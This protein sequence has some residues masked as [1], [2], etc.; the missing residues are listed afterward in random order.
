MKKILHVSLL[1]L[2][3]IIFLSCSEDDN[4]GGLRLQV[5][6]QAPVLRAVVKD[7]RGQI[8]IQENLSENLYSF[9]SSPVFPLVAMSNAKDTFIDVDFDGNR[10]ASDIVF[11]DTLYSISNVLS[12]ATTAL[13]E[14]ADINSTTLDY[15]V[16]KYKDALSQY[17]H[18]F[19]ISSDDILHKTPLQSKKINL[20]VL[21]DT[22]YDAR[23]SV[24]FNA[25]DIDGLDEKFNTVYNFYNEY[26]NTKEVAEAARYYAFYNALNLLDKKKII[27][28]QQNTMPS[29]PAR[30]NSDYK[31]NIENL[32]SSAMLSSEYNG[33]SNLAYWAMKVDDINDIAYIASGN[34][35]MD[36]VDITSATQRLQ[37]LD[38]N[39]SGFGTSVEYMD[40][41]N[42]RC[43]FLADQENQ[44][45]IYGIWG[46]DS[47]KPPYPHEYPHE[48]IGNYRS[49]TAGAKTFD[50]DYTRT[51][52]NNMELLLVSNTTAG[53]EIF[54]IRDM[55]CNGS[56]DLNDSH[57]LNSSAIGS[58]THSSVVASNQ[59]IIYIADGANGLISVDISGSQPVELNA[60]LLTNNEK[61]YNLHMVPNSNELYVSTDNGIQIY[62]TDNT[63][64][65]V[66]RGLYVT[67]G[68]RANVLGETLRVSLSQNHRA[69]FVA[70]ITA[71]MK[72]ID[73]TDSKNPELCGSAYFSA[74]NIV[75]RSAVR[76]VTLVEHDDG[77]KQVYVANDSNGLIRI[78]DARDLLFEH[79]KGLLD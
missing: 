75:Q 54:D 43:I 78:E 13:L 74:L 77:S 60:S 65:I 70:D 62:N 39:L 59:K 45:V 12:L 68:S 8:A 49:T 40:R 47:I 32:P 38:D 63:G 25:S 6:S 44:L 79:C 28:S 2:T 46:L 61:A 56:V 16:T 51:N 1:L 42:S 57:R 58:D 4:S 53:L 19:S 50:V 3:S 73:V 31:D 36:V 11:N 27:R 41:N 52:A 26:L 14:S 9:T 33:A 17:T 23:Q 5:Y 18:A 15:N 29:I 76:D 24:D 22:L 10:S 34:D 7:A 64:R 35:G 72:I 37:N 66:Y 71:G 48:L 20:A 55:D 21:T 67:E 30:L 69:L